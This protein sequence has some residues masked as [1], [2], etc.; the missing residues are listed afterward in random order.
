MDIIILRYLIEFSIL[1]AMDHS[2][3]HGN[4]LARHFGQEVWST[5]LSHS[6]DAAF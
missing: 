3:S 6:F 2:T 1:Q 5:R 4:G